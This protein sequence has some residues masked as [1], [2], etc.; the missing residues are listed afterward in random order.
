MASRPLTENERRILQ[1]IAREHE[2]Q[3]RVKPGGWHVYGVPYSR[4]GEPGW[5]WDDYRPLVADGLLEKSEDWKNVYVRMT[6]AGWA[7]LSESSRVR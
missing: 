6:E 3:R 2:E 7:A 4:A 1:D 5:E